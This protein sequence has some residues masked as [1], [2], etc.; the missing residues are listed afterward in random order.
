MKHHLSDLVAWWQS[1]VHTTEPTALASLGGGM[2][3]LGAVAAG[4]TRLAGDAVIGLLV[5]WTFQTS[6]NRHA[7]DEKADKN[8][9]IAK[10]EK[11][12]DTKLAEMKAPVDQAMMIFD[13]HNSEYLA[14][15]GEVR[16][17]RTE[18]AVAK[19]DMTAGL[20]RVEKEVEG[21]K[22]NIDPSRKIGK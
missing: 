2:M 18:L 10:V 1:I 9:I 16:H 12:F 11:S 5:L 19:V 7:A 22:Q 20:G 17:M 6:L 4:E 13:G 3:A 8:E 14:L 15:T 21:L